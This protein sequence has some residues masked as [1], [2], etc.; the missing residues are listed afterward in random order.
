MKS[1]SLLLVWVLATTLFICVLEA[2]DNDLE[3]V[4]ELPTKSITVR[5]GDSL[6]SIVASIN[7][8]TYNNH[9]LVGI[10]KRINGLS[11]SI[12]S[13]GQEIQVPVLKGGEIK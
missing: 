11:T 8:G 10:L 1:L 5:S 6:W 2:M 9:F 13:P 4:L 3:E 12:V 7:D